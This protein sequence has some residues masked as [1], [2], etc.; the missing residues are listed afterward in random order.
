MTFE[1]VF[2]GVSAWIAVSVLTGLAF[3]AF[4][5]AGN[6]KAEAVKDEEI[7]IYE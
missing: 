7:G 2:L 6:S 5:K 3:G 1:T 4:A